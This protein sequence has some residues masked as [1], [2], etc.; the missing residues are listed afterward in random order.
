[1][2]TLAEFNAMFHEVS[3]RVNV[4]IQQAENYYYMPRLMAA[5]RYEPG[6]QTFLLIWRTIGFEIAARCYRLLERDMRNHHLAALA[7]MLDDDTLLLQMLPT[8]NR[9]GKRTEAGLKRTRNAIVRDIRALQRSRVFARIEIFRIRF[10]AH[11]QP[12]PKHL[13]RLPRSMR[14]DANVQNMKAADVRELTERISALCVRIADLIG[15][16]NFHPDTVASLARD[17]AKQLWEPVPP[18]DD[19]LHFLKR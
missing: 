1:M 16:T 18:E 10:V 12:D 7:R 15:Y 8:Y 5:R 3:T 19:P 4:L 6:G 2:A 13:T 9:T 14:K 17:D 11:R